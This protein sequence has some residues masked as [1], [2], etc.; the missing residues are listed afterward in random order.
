MS[1]YIRLNFTA[2]FEVVLRKHLVKFYMFSGIYSPD[3]SR[4]IK[5]AFREKE[6]STFMNLVHFK[7]YLFIISA[8]PFIRCLSTLPIFISSSFILYLLYL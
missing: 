8:S 4:G 7:V 1:L 2:E 5:V 3:F 6:T